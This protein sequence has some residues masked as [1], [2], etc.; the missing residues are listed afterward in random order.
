LKKHPL[1][2]ALRPDKMTLAALEMTLRIYQSGDPW[3][4]IPILRRIARPAEDILSACG[5]IARVVREKGLTVDIRATVSEIGGGSL[6][7]RTLP[8][9]SVVLETPNVEHAAR[10]L[11]QARI[12]VFG[13]I[14]KGLLVLDLRAVDEAE[15]ALLI[16]TVESTKSRL[17]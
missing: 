2:R 16:E 10:S 1:A 15:E 12:P 17:M 11:R 3:Q 14:E 9:W 13:R 5:R 4:E 8:S 6:P 7:G